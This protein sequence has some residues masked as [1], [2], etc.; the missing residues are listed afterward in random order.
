MAGYQTDTERGRCLNSHTILCPVF[1]FLQV[2]VG[3]GCGC[4][5][6]L[7]WQDCLPSLLRNIILKE[8]KG[9]YSLFT[10]WCQLSYLFFSCFV[11]Y[12]VLRFY[13]SVF[14]WKQVPR[15]GSQEWVISI[16]SSQRFCSHDPSILLKIT[17]DFRNF[18]LCGL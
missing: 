3:R 2:A 6:S 4:E 10:S 15:P 14:C 16:S 8:R 9:F 12:F 1:L 11:F 13:N 18:Y 17:E 5:P 7:S